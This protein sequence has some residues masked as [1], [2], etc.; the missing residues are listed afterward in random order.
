MAVTYKKRYET[1]VEIW[2]NMRRTKYLDNACKG[3]KCKKKYDAEM[4]MKTGKGD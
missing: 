3:N 2:M 1:M 4:R